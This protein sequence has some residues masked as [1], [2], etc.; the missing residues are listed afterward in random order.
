M[1]YGLLVRDKNA[2]VSHRKALA[3]SAVATGL[4]DHRPDRNFVFRS[5]ARDIGR[6]EGA[7]A[8][9][10]PE[11]GEDVAGGALQKDRIPT[12]AGHQRRRADVVQPG[13]PV[14]VVR[15]VEGIESG[16]KPLGRAL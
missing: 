6:K 13:G 16:A 11:I 8:P 10:Q 5:Q 12:L 14:H 3:L 15:T 4:A 9:R 2:L 1:R 7:P